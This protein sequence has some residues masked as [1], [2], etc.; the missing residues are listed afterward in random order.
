M[1]IALLGKLPAEQA[2]PV[3]DYL[4]SLAADRVPAVDGDDREKRQQ[5]WSAWWQANG[6]RIELPDRSEELAVQRYL[7]YTLLIQQQ[8]NQVVELDRAGKVRW[9]LTGLLSPQDARVLP[10]DRVLVSEYAGLRVTE[11]NLKGEVLWQKAVPTNP[12]NV[13]RLPSGNT[14]IA[15]RTMFLE[16][17]RT[18]KEITRITRPLSDVM[19]AWRL[20]DGQIVCL[21]NRSMY[22][23]LD[24]TG[25]ELKSF[26]LQGVSNFGND[27]LPNGNVLVPLSWQNKVTEYDPSGKVVWEASVVQPMAATRLANGHTLIS[28][29]QWPAKIIEVDRTGKQVAVLP[30]ATYTVRVRRR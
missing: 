24:R 30:A 19:S 4:R 27:L 22:L 16:V 2:V 25:K 20:P 17:D 21:T 10:G 5:A 26:R 13:Q 12:L 28:C 11:R 1:L 3:E 6:A 8:L 9:T 15:G 7:G 18:G 14:F 23:R 29:Q